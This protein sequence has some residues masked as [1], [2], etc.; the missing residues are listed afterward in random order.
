MQKKTTVQL[1][2]IAVAALALVFLSVP[3]LKKEG[4]RDARPGTFVSSVGKKVEGQKVPEQM[5][6]LPRMKDDKFYERINRVAAALP[7]DRDPFSFEDRGVPGPQEGLELT[8]ILWEGAKP[9]AV[10]NQVFMNEGDS[11]EG[12]AVVKILKDHVVLK[13]R[14]GEFELRLKP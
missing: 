5:I 3:L 13:D 4:V 12:F 7:I 10:I 1:G 2:V 14:S 9:T 8:G 11:N 6:K